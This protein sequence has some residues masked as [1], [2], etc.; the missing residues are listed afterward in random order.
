MKTS[1]KLLA[2][3]AIYATAASAGAA[4]IVNESFQNYSVGTLT[5]NTTTVNAT[6]LT[7]NI[8][9]PGTNTASITSGTMTY[10]NGSLS[11]DGGN[12]YLSIS[13]TAAS[14]AAVNE[15]LAS[16]LA[17]SAGSFY[18]SFLYR[19]GGTINGGDVASAGFQSNVATGAN[20]SNNMNSQSSGSSFRTVVGA[21]NTSNGTLTAGSVN[22]IV[23]QFISS[24][25]QWTGAN[26]WTNPNSAT[27]GASTYTVSGA[28]SATTWLALSSLGA[29]LD[30]GDSANFDRYLIGSSWT[31]VVPVPEPSTWLLLALSGTFF[32]V[33]RR[34]KMNG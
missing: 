10:N 33:M 6:G 31:D 7:G 5:D 2:T 32:M 15:Q 1:L 30:A 26:V 22:F 11:F 18:M 25:T 27:Q 24:G 13:G 16:S 3:I 4:V 8:R 23:V 29:N 17:P 9:V 20:S 34:R 19:F 12:Q 21:A 28:T 14:G